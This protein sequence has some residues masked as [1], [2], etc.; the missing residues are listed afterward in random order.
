[1]FAAGVL[2]LAKQHNNWSWR[3]RLRGRQ[4]AA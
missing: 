2:W 4:A 1:V 3:P